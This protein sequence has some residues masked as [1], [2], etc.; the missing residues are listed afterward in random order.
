MPFICIDASNQVRSRKYPNSSLARL[1][2]IG[3][4]LC[5][6]ST[7]EQRR[8][9]VGTLEPVALRLIERCIALHLDMFDLICYRRL[10]CNVLRTLENCLYTRQLCI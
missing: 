10:L 2:F 5:Q 8:T 7:V 4:F 1:F 3:A 9:H 6:T